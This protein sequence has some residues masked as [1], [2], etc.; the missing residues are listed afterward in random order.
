MQPF[1]IVSL[2]GQEMFSE[3]NF[4]LFLPLQNS[5]V[6]YLETFCANSVSGD[7]GTLHRAAFSQ[8]KEN[9]CL[10]TLCL[11]PPLQTQ[12]C[13]L[14]VRLLNIGILE[15]S[16]LLVDFFLRPLR[17]CDPGVA[18]KWTKYLNIRIVKGV[19]EILIVL[20]SLKSKIFGFSHWLLN[21]PRTSPANFWVHAQRK[22][23]QN[24]PKRHFFKNS[25][26]IG[27]RTKQMSFPSFWG[28]IDVKKLSPF[29]DLAEQSST[30]GHLNIIGSFDDLDQKCQ[31][32]GAQKKRRPL[33]HANIPPKWWNRHLFCAF[34]N[35]GWEIS[36]FQKLP[37]LDRFEP[38]FFEHWP[39]SW[40]EMCWIN[41]RASD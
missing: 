14:E 21:W 24:C 16:R 2:S 5:N 19:P 29:F 32:S 4:S 9:L 36:K 3:I 34:T 7:G 38:F 23:A 22:M 20:P 31:Y 6:V 11:L 27:K 28:D 12:Y 15:V 8:N 13:E 39:K 26:K 25:S 30:F 40:L 18:K 17:P 35:F 37:F 1:S 41:L 10:F 33:F